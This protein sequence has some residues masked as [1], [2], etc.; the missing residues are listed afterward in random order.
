MEISE[1]KLPGI[2][3]ITPSVYTD[4]RGYFFED[5]QKNRYEQHGIPAFVQSN[6][7]RSKRNVL[8]GLHYQEPQAQ[9]KLVGV[10]RG[11]VWDVVV[12]IRPESVTFGQ[13]FGITLSDE[14]HTQMYIP[15]GFAH[16]FCVLSDEADFYYKC[17]EY[18]APSCEHGIAWNDKTLAIDWPITNPILAAKDEQYPRFD[19]LFNK[20]SHE[21]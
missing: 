11:T 21:K 15:P 1:A 6:L 10:T 14:N 4:T 8:R 7:S 18:Y 5:F 12:D 20:L 13:W 9:G 3:I 17:T 19:I 16:G 2:L